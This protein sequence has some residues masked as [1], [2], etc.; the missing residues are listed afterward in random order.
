MNYI[1]EKIQ[2]IGASRYSWRP[3]IPINSG[4]VAL[5]ISVIAVAF[6]VSSSNSPCL[7]AQTCSVG[8]D[9]EFTGNISLKGGTANLGTFEASGITADRTWT[10]PDETG[11]LA[12]SSGAL[13]GLKIMATDVGGV[14]TTTDIYPLSVGT[15]G[16]VL[17]VDPTASFLEYSAITGVPT[18]SADS[19]VTTDG[20]GA[21]TTTDI[22][23]LSVGTIGQ[24]LTVD[25]TASFLEYSAITGVPT[26]SADSF[27]ITDG[28]GALTTTSLIPMSFGA[29]K[30][31]VSDASGNLTDVTLTANTPMK[32]DANGNTSASDLVPETDLTVGSGVAG[33]ILTVNAAASALEFQT[34]AGGG[35]WTLKASGHS[36]TPT[37]AIDGGSATDD[38]L[39]CW[40]GASS[41]DGTDG[42]YFRMTNGKQYKLVIA[43]DGSSGNT[44]NASGH[45][46]QGFG[47]LS[48]QYDCGT[49]ATCTTC[50]GYSSAYANMG[51]WFYT[52]SYNSWQQGPTN[53]TNDDRCYI[54]QNQSMQS[55]YV[56]QGWNGELIMNSSSAYWNGWNQGIK[57]VYTYNAP[58]ID[59]LSSPYYFKVPAWSDG[60]CINNDG[61]A[62]GG[63]N[64]TSIGNVYGLYFHDYRPTNQTWANETILYFLYESNDFLN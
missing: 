47:L 63:T 3:Y 4:S 11:T 53:G 60:V 22:Y 61:N 16:Q 13:S 27:V 30:P 43:T 1:K 23:P 62:L 5:A 42:S 46:G 2:K 50:S 38:V 44:N 45:N 31:I 55:S 28:A 8:S 9:N 37:T 64:L 21:L 56:P 39:I 20:A 40:G 52:G 41:T 7:Q 29:N 34:V 17:T 14:A 24:V 32:T 48:S 35:Q 54:L 51:S 59:L 19:F 12:L 6:V 57:T 33:Q 18:L 25:P 58:V 49:G 15:I 10:L 36:M 26:L